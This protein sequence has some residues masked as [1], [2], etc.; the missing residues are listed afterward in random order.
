MADFR[1]LLN[2]YMKEAGCT[3]I[4]LSERS[5]I[6]GSTLSRYRLGTRI[7]DRG[8]RQVWNIAESLHDLG[9]SENPETIEDRLNQTLS[10][11]ELGF[12]H[13]GER[14][15]DL[16]RYF[17]MNLTELA[18]A[19]HFDPSY[20]SRIRQ[21]NRHPSKPG[22]FA[23]Q[24]S[25]YVVENYDSAENRAKAARLM[26]CRPQD[27][28]GTGYFNH[29][30]HWFRAGDLRH[31]GPA[32]QFLRRLDHFRQSAYQREHHPFYIPPLTLP[33]EVSRTGSTHQE[34]KEAELDFL[35][36]TAIG[37]SRQPVFM[38]SDM[39]GQV[40]SEDPD[41]QKRWNQGLEKLLGKGLVVTLIENMERPFG[42]LV[43]DMTSR[44]PSYMTGSLASGCLP[45]TPTDIFRRLF[46]SS[47]SVSL[48]GEYI[49]GPPRNERFLLSSS[50]DQ[51]ALARDRAE[52]L[53]SRA[54]PLL[55]TFREENAEDFRNFLKTTLSEEDGADRY[56]TSLPFWT[57]TESLL[58]R[59]LK[60]NRVP[61]DETEK[62]MAELSR[63]RALT[64]KFL[65][66]KQLRDTVPDPETTG[67]NY[68]ALTLPWTF[69][70]RKLECTPRQLKDHLRETERMA[71]ACEN[72]SLDLRSELLFRNIEVTVSGDHTAVI[73]KKSDPVVHFAVRWPEL[74]TS[75]D[76][77]MKSNNH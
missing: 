45:D 30:M 66:D 51:L 46:F 60:H 72:Y 21:G 17:G 67:R 50:E 6:S 69:S 27:L 26:G 9:V 70:E 32:Y 15:D 20:L 4:Q 12:D 58:R 22:T 55:L 59:I 74:V 73:S 7:P 44:I 42:D 8:S 41:F 63:E 62:Y 36:L 3:G 28:E 1:D 61:E 75:I 38:Y 19:L 23:E 39:P 5:G 31:Q 33:E 76:Q 53:L 49:D 47:G 29:L 64:E 37:K 25:R 68:P 48:T 13:V 10:D 34:L 43:Q 71:E 2:A 56:L 65:E 40:P 18:R 54:Q 11:A 57:L 52:S 14:L 16:T 24:I 35:H 77:C